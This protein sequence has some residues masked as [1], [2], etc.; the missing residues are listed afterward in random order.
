MIEWEAEIIFTYL[1]ST[2][3]NDDKGFKSMSPSNWQSLNPSPYIS[4]NHWQDMI[5]ST[6][7][8]TNECMYN[9]PKKTKFVKKLWFDLFL[10]SLCLIAPKCFPGIDD[11][12]GLEET[13]KHIFICKNDDSVE[14]WHVNNSQFQ[15]CLKEIDHP[16]TLNLIS[17][18]HEA[19]SKYF[20]YYSVNEWITFKN[21]INFL[22]DFWVFP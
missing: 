2:Q 13:I 18:I 11:E 22:Q 21:Y 5:L 1:T 17:I 15:E 14:S 10:K 6:N 3:N 7:A 20:K 16:S 12:S 8:R 19:L 4:R 9:G